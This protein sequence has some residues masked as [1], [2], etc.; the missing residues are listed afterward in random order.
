LPAPGPPIRI[1]SGAATRAPDS[2]H[3]KEKTVTAAP[4]FFASSIGKKVVMAVTGLGL[5][6]FVV[7]HMVGNLQAYLG[8]EVF[9][10]Y[11]A[12]LRAVP[13]LLWGMRIALLGAAL[14]HVWAAVSL[15][16][17]NRA[18]R[19][20]GYRERESRASTYAS[21]TMRWSGVIL[22]LFIVYHLMHFTFGTRAVHP[23][24]VHGD[25]YH[26]FVTG[27]QNPLVSLFY[28]AAMACLGLHMYHG[29]WS[30]LQTVGLSHPRY[31]PWRRRFAAALTALVVLA[32][33]SFPLAV[34]SGLITDARV[35]ASARAR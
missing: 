33:V 17:M 13:A 15:T 7:A 22:L 19:P 32:N 18:A 26:N 21:R 30:M 5:F 6:G 12:K 14:L 4:R 2:P 8:P 9:N 29:V 3:Q 11:A 27:F 34:L 28:L 23:Q 31:N 35:V 20:R 16:R 25:A 10:G 24:F 1:A